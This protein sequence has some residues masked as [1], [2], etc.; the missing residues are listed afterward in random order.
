VWIILAILVV[1]AMALPQL[2]S[3]HHTAPQ[4]VS[5]PEPVK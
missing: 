1:L 4:T 2:A 3:K 5:S